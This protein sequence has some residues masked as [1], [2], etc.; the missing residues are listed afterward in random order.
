MNAKLKLV[1]AT[2]IGSMALSPL[3]LSKNNNTGQ[4][5]RQGVVPECGS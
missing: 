1:A 5:A 4:A 2:L 3:S